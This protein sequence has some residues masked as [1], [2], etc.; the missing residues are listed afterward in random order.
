MAWLMLLILTIFVITA[1]KLDGG[2]LLSPR[3]LLCL[4]ILA[5]YSVI[6]FNYKNWEVQISP[7]FILYVS[8]AIV[9]WILGGALIKRLSKHSSRV[10][11]NRLPL[12]NTCIKYK[13]PVNFFLILSVVLTFLYV[14]KLLSD[15]GAVGGFSAIL[16]A[17]Y[18]NTVNGYTP[19]F[20]FNQMREVVVAI[21]YVNTFRFFQRLFSKS[22]K[23]S[24]VKLLIPIAMDMVLILITTDRN[25][26]LRYAIYLACLYVLF[27][28]ENKNFKNINAAIVRR[29]AVMVIAVVAVFFVMGVAKQYTSNFAR[30]ISIYGGSGLYNFNLWLDNQTVSS[31]GSATFST[32]LRVISELLERIGV[33]TGWNT[34]AR[35]DE[36]II[37]TSSNGYVYSS[38]IYSALKPFVEDMGYFG[39]VFF[40]FILGVFYQWLYLRAKRN[41]YKFSWVLYCMLIY[42]VVFFPIAEQLFHRFTLGFVYEIAWLAIVYYGVY[43]KRRVVRTARRTVKVAQ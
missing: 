37:F 27:F 17:I 31:T 2:D 22:D 6:I 23:I 43:G 4:A 19:G 25:I 8:T 12:C 33:T 24:I 21:A 34:A 41:K 42:P 38:N 29:V 10:V 20:V 28:R 18:E 39:V 40:P 26:L 1:Y 30:S 15:A 9:A 13:Y 14:F 16:R 11:N 3:F 35:F 36:Y 32:F 5:S 7:K